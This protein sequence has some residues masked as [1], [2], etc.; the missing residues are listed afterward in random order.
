M[1]LGV[2]DTLLGVLFLIFAAPSLTTRPT[3]FSTGTPC[4]LH[5]FLFTLLH[6]VA[7]WTICGL[8]CDR[9]YA[10]AAP[11]HYGAL[12]N[13]KKVP[14]GGKIWA[15]YNKLEFFYVLGGNWFGFGLV[16]FNIIMFTA[17]IPSCTVQ[18][19]HVF[20][21]LCAR[22]YCRWWC[23]LVLDDIHGTNFITASSFN[24]RL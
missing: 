24:S 9:Y 19:Q 1:H 13:P 3:W 22:L 14:N 17:I 23:Y 8:N 18:L 5:G 16:H 11:L 6:P 4:T 10:I 20:R 2:V 15:T 7:L 21:C 12:V